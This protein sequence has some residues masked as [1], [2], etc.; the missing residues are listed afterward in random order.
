MPASGPGRAWTGL[1]A[2][3]A[4]PGRVGL[5]AR[6]AATHP[7][8]GNLAPGC[9][10]ARL[11]CPA[12][13]PDPA[14]F[15]TWNWTQR[16]D[17]WWPQASL[18]TY[19]VA[20]ILLATFP[21]AALMCFQILDKVR[22]E[23][24]QIETRLA[25]SAFALSQAVD[26]ELVA[27]LDALNALAQGDSF[28]CALAQRGRLQQQLRGGRPAA[29]RLGQRLPGR[30]A[31]RSAV[32]LGRRPRRRVGGGR[33]GAAARARAAPAPFGRLRPGAHARARRPGGDAGGAGGAH[34]ADHARAG[35]AR[36]RQRLA[37]AGRF[38]QPAR[39]R[40]RAAVRRGPAPDRLDARARRAAGHRA[41]VG[42]LGLDRR[43]VRRHAAARGR[44]RA[45]GLCGLAAGA[46]VGL[47]RAG[48]GA[49]AADRLGAPAGDPGRPLHQRRLPA[50]GLAARRAGGAPGRGAAA[51]AG[52]AGS[53][54]PARTHHGARS[55]PAARRAA[56]RRPPRRACA[57]R[58]GGGHRQAQAGRGAT[59][60]RAR[61]AAGQPAPDRP[62]AGSRQRGLLPLP[63]RGRRAHLD[64]RPLPAVRAGLAAAAARWSAGSN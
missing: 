20:V 6:R 46:R 11:P 43:A 34:G 57:P 9:R 55:R 24:D 49:R 51:G 40:L 8:P 13:M 47:G 33:T 12:L 53:G 4:S 64:T 27:S 3:K 44:R 15:R 52:P 2:T 50:A 36:R 41:G 19:L 31:R 1:R 26:R 61:A 63:L 60:R 42:C 17:R 48:R 58:A 7:F 30:C 25:G 62:G 59:P 5:A 16:L 38:G 18:R 14:P 54:R 37:A 32:R 22:V 35:R 56:C 29:A 21:L 39:G 23:Q 45:R 10:V 28:F